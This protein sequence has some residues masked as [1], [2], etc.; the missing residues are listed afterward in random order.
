MK[1][2]CNIYLYSYRVNLEHL[3]IQKTVQDV[4]EVSKA[5]KIGTLFSDV[6]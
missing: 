6:E 3:R 4:T 5:Q 1:S 2:S